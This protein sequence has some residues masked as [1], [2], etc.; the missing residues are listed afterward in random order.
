MLT[1]CDICQRHVKSSCQ[2]RHRVTLQLCARCTV[3][4]YSASNLFVFD[5]IGSYRVE[6][7][8]VVEPGRERHT[9]KVRQELSGKR[10]IKFVHWTLGF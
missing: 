9:S 2:K 4:L 3:Y 8:V 6:V 1:R 10:G 7:V 5:D